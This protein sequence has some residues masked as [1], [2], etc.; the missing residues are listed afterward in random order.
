V[1]FLLLQFFKPTLLFAASDLEQQKGLFHQYLS[2]EPFIVAG[3]RSFFLIIALTVNYTYRTPNLAVPLQQ[4]VTISSIIRL[5]STFFCALFT[6]LR[7]PRVDSAQSSARS[8]SIAP[9]E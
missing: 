3:Q 4:L 6:F 1:L 5:L 7:H 8:I 2:R 9:G